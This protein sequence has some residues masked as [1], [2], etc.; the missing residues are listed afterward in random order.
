MKPGVLLSGAALLCAVPALAAQEFQVN[1]EAERLV[2]FISKAP[3]DDFDGVTD[4]ID[5]YV[6]LDAP[7]LVDATGGDGTAFYFEVEL[8]SLD[9]GIGLRNRHMRRDYLEVDE[10]PYAT[11]EGSVATVRP[12]GDGMFEM[13][14]EGTF[15]VHGVSRPLEVPCR[16]APEGEGFRVTCAFQVLLSDFDI[17]IPH[18][19]FLKLAD[20]IR[21][22]LDFAVIPPG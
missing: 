12:V 16:A 2:R 13:V 17:D 9:T 4:R 20:E 15:G 3:I 19:M 7:G 8:A 6:L 22:E 10:H 18:V 5:G 21:L 1:L 11:F 14:T